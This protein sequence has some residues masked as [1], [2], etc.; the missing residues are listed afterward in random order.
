MEKKLKTMIEDETL[1]IADETLNKVLKAFRNG[2]Y[3]S[4][5]HYYSNSQIDEMV[6]SRPLTKEE[7]LALLPDQEGTDQFDCYG[8]KF[9]ELILL[10]SN[11]EEDRLKWSRFCS[12]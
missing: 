9:L 6:E 12:Q 1:K 2:F 8:S 5:D 4:Y 3:K 7:F 10:F 11:S